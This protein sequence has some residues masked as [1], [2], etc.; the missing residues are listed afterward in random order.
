M[1][2]DGDWPTAGVA[3]G[4]VAALL[5]AYSVSFAD[6]QILS[7]LVGPIKADLKLSDTQFS[8]L[9]GLALEVA[10]FVCTAPRD[11]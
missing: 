4:T 11:C 3:W 5:L 9:A 7:L 1:N 6:R 10:R 8:L 2:D